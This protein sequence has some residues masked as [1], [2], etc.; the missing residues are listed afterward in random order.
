MLMSYNPHA[1]FASQEQAIAAAKAAVA[2][3]RD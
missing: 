3:L 2:W 1:I